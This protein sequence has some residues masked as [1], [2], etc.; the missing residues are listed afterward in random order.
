MQL[1]N[2]LTQ[3]IT[4]FLSNIKNDLFT[5]NFKIFIN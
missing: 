3:F 2:E 5:Y 1:K 4:L